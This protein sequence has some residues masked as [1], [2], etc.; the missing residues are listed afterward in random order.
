MSGA[1]GSRPSLTRSG[2][3]VASDRANLASQSAS[4]RSSLQRRFE[5][6][7]ARKTSSL[8]SGGPATEDTNIGGNEVAGA[9]D[10]TAIL[11]GGVLQRRLEVSYEGQSGAHDSRGAPAATINRSA[12][13]PSKRRPTR[14]TTLR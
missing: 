9:P 14:A 3:P 1:V 2:T 8:G 4:G 13:R 10:R 5:I 12:S 7:M 6:A 11:R